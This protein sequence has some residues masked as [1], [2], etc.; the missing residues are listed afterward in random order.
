MS[1]RRSRAPRSRKSRNSDV[2]Q[3]D[4]AAT[5]PATDSIAQLVAEQVDPT[6]TGQ[7]RALEAGWDELLS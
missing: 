7:L 6:Q 2:P 3:T 5:T 4:V 1:T